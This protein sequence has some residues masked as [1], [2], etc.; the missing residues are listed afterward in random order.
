[1]NIDEEFKKWTS[2]E[3]PNFPKELKCYFLWC[4]LLK[5][6][7]TEE[8]S[9]MLIGAFNQIL[10][11]QKYIFMTGEI[12]LF[13]EIYQ[14]VNQKQKSTEVEKLLLQYKNIKDKGT[15]LVANYSYALFRMINGRES[16][17]IYVEINNAKRKKLQDKMHFAKVAVIEAILQNDQKIIENKLV[18]LLSCH[19]AVAK[20]GLIK[21]SPDRQI[22][23]SAMSFLA[24]LRQ[25]GIR[26]NIDDQY[27][28]N[29]YLDKY[30]PI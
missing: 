9:K 29:V 15:S 12:D 23:V 25:K 2:E 24:L 27:I 5:M 28:S 19:H 18:E 6:N 21:A 11:N 3:K 4:L 14:L 22:C 26:I 1:M 10:I 17:E 20:R 8:A 30:F 16:D 13:I 7:K